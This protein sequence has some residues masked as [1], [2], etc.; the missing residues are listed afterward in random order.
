MYTFPGISC[1]VEGKMFRAAVPIAAAAGA[2]GLFLANQKRNG[3]PMAGSPFSVASGVDARRSMVPSSGLGSAV[4]FAAAAP[5]AGGP[6][7]AY[8]F[9]VSF[10]GGVLSCGCVGFACRLVAEALG[11]S[12]DDVWR[13]RAKSS[14]LT[15]G[16]PFAKE[17]SC[18]NKS[19]IWCPYGLFFPTRCWLDQWRGRWG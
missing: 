1:V 10:A 11:G 7:Q 9:A 3:S 18:F 5:P 6:S 8:T 2:G 4:A 13:G 12:Q 15:A 17:E 16:L 14:C 19:R